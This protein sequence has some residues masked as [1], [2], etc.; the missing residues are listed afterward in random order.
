MSEGMLIITATHYSGRLH[1]GLGSETG[2]SYS[3]GESVALYKNKISQFFAKFFNVGMDIEVD[4]KTRCV[5]K[6]S[7]KKH[8]QSLELNFDIS[9]IQ[10]S[11]YEAT[12]RKEIK[13]DE[14]KSEI[15][16]HAKSLL[17]HNF[18]D[19]KRTKLFK[20]MVKHL[21]IGNTDQVKKLIRKGAY[22]DQAFF[23]FSPQAYYLG[24]FFETLS[25]IKNKAESY[26]NNANFYSYT[27]LALAIERKN[28]DLI[29]FL[30][31][32]SD[33]SGEKITF[34]YNKYYA[35]GILK[36]EKIQ[37]IENEWKLSQI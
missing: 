8:F 7:L 2:P 26:F 35:L 30:L 19:K 16:S 27:A 32:Y 29:D 1:V 12:I 33:K 31:L 37:Q 24:H 9:K 22:V 28:K 18:S 17:G 20:K 4:G 21:V 13:K 10:K 5:N 36:R 34:S 6:N 14:K 15:S 23:K 25:K 11:G 3:C